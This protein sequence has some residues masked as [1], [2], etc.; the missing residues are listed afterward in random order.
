M[1]LDLSTSLESLSISIKIP[2]RDQQPEVIMA[3][4]VVALRN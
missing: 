4:R 1:G 3:A 2:E